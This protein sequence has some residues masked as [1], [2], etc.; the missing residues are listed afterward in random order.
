MFFFT[1]E[2]CGANSSFSYC[3]SPCPTSCYDVRDPTNSLQCVGRSCV[4]GCFCDAGFVLEGDNCV[5][6][7]SCGCVYDGVY[8]TVG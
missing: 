8:H 2:Q 5:P 3:G 6:M 1:A 4:E 7:E